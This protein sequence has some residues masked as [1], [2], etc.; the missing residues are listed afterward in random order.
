MSKFLFKK[1]YES[2]FV[3][4]LRLLKYKNKILQQHN[5]WKNQI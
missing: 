4:F 1:K 5:L 2:E 3:R